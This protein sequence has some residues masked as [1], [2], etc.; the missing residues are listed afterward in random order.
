[1]S[2]SDRVTDL[3]M[4][5]YM[6]HGRNRDL[7]KYLRL[8]R[9]SNATRSSSDGSL[10]CLDELQ[11]RACRSACDRSGVGKSME[12]LSTLRKKA[13]QQQLEE[14]EKSLRNASAESAKSVAK[15]SP[16][17]VGTD[18]GG[19]STDANKGVTVKETKVEHK[20]GRNFNFNLESVIEINLPPPSTITLGVP[21]TAAPVAAITYTQ[22]EPLPQSQSVMKQIS[23]RIVVHENSTQ[24]VASE[25]DPIR[26]VVKSHIP[27]NAEEPLD[28]TKDLSPVSSIASNKQRLEWDSLGDI[29]YDSSERL[30]FCGAADLNETE[31]RC[32]QRYFARKGLTF[33][34]SVIVVRQREEKEKKPARSGEDTSIMR[35]K[36]D[37]QST[38]KLQPPPPPPA[39]QRK[40][41]EEA[42]STQTTLHT[43]GRE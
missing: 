3:I 32:L 24:T 41:R 12:N 10:P 21:T 15:N 13:E 1:M 42:K 23:P 29:G 33:D 37:A 36:P 20:S 22:P 14:S 19:G 6:E 39:V 18:A 27:G 43:R 35:T 25:D 34:R 30:Q 8:R 28:S 11:R 16:D 40:E 26:P 7:E 17:K 9:M 2:Q 31:K 4:H 38:P 5:Y